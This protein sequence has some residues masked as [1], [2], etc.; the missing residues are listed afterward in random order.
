PFL[1]GYSL[2]EGRR[3]AFTQALPRM[4]EARTGKTCGRFNNKDLAMPGVLTTG[5][6]TWGDFLHLLRNTINDERSLVFVDGRKMMVN[7][8]WIRDHVHVLKA[9]RHWEYD[10]AGYVDFTLRHQRADGCILELVKQADDRHWRYA[11]PE[12]RKFFPDDNLAMCRLDIEADVEY[13]LVE[14]ATYCYRISG[15]D[16]WLARALPRLEKAID[17][18]TSDPQRWDARHGLVKRGYTIDTWDFTYEPASV[19]NRTLTAATPQAIM[20]GDNSGVYQAMAQLAWLNGR[21]GRT[22]KAAAWRAR[23]DALKAAMYKHL[24]NGRFFFHQLPLNVPP[25]DAHERERLSLSAAYDMN[26]GL[27]PVADCR[28]TIE[29]FRRRRQTTDCFAEWFTVDPPYDFTFARHPRGDYVNGGVCL[30]TAG[31]LAKAALENGYEAYGWDILVRVKEMAARDGTLYFLYDRTTATSINA[32]LGP[33]AWGAASVL[34]AFD[35]ALAGVRDAGVRYDAIRFSPRWPV[36]GLDEVR[37]FTGY[38]AADA[39][40]DV[41]YVRRANGLRY[42]VRAPA[43]A[44]AAHILLPSG[45]AAREVWLNGAPRAF[46]TT[47][48]GDSRYVDFETEGTGTYDIEILF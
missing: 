3:V 13:L 24:W 33:S 17:Y 43:K 11:A 37:Y 27:M 1:E 29:E 38:E 30:F 40:V 15:D 20:H 5:D 42:L 26:R 21:L 2:N 7:K 22:A 10:Y 35:E 9:M 32:A 16:A 39:V 31:E 23:A 36:T 46:E 19:T 48:V 45:A 18:V 44:L 8:N 6:P 34:S 4:R 25:V 28:R 14:G 47:A 41:R 12:S